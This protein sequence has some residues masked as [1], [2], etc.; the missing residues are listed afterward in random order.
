MRDPELYKKTKQ[1]VQ[2]VI[3]LLE[4]NKDSHP[5]IIRG[6]FSVTGDNSISH[7][8]E[9]KIDW[10]RGWINFGPQIESLP[11]Y[12]LAKEAMEGH[13][14]ARSRGRELVW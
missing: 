6:R 1:A 5:T 8:D 10:V 13:E 12:V 11:S 7:T 14:I 9:V 3:N 4:S 2:D